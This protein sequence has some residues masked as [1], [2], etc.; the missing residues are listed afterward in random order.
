MSRRLVV[1]SHPCVRPVNQTVYRV[2]RERGWDVK[3]VVPDRWRDDFARRPFAS[4]ALEGLEDAVVPVRVMFPGSTQ[5]HIYR[6]RA[7]PIL[8]E[9]SPDLVFL[10]EESFSLPAFQWGRAAARLG[11]PFGIQAAEN[12]DRPLPLVA[13]GIRRWV[14]PRARFVVSRSPRAGRLAVR[15]GATGHVGLAPHAVPAWPTDGNGNRVDPFTVGYAGRLVPEKGI[16]VLAR[17]MLRLDGHSRLLVVGEGPLAQ[18]VED[19]ASP[20]LDVEL[21]RN[22]RHDDMH[23]VFRRMDVL[24]LPSRT[25]RKWAEQFGRVLVEA[26]SQSVPA[27]GSDSGEIPWV[28]ETTG[29]GLVVPEG[30]DV[31]LA[32]TLARLRDLPDHRRDLGRRGREGVEKL[33]SA[34]AAATAFE[35]LLD[36]ALAGEAA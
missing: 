35:N 2:L 12:L 3:I 34:E 11:L 33:F 28:I 27:V 22:V 4:Q 19:L 8:R 29:G 31:A 25:T 32:D 26:M 13:R 20:A 6:A 16:D 9:L 30:D 10:E 1:V 21:L 17:A 7:A 24:V 15:W 18:F 36:D 5:R 14:L 23:A